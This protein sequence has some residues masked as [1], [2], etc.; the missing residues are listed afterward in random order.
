M[1]TQLW[2]GVLLHPPAPARGSGSTTSHSP[3][4]RTLSHVGKGS[5]RSKPCGFGTSGTAGLCCLSSCPLGSRGR[6]TSCFHTGRTLCFGPPGFFISYSQP[7]RVCMY[8]QCLPPA[9][10]GSAEATDAL[11]IKVILPLKLLGKKKKKQKTN[12]AEKQKEFRSLLVALFS[13][14]QVKAN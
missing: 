7:A 14:R 3:G 8:L 4:P 13:L 9:H 12:A 6:F 1:L 11:Q 2:D 10:Q 5:E